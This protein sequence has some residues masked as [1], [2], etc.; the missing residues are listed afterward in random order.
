MAQAF[1]RLSAPFFTSSDANNMR[2]LFRSLGAILLISTCTTAEWERGQ[3][4]VSGDKFSVVRTSDEFQQG[5]YPYLV[6]GDKKTSL[7]QCEKLCLANPLCEYGTFVTA[8]AA[9]HSVEHNYVQ[10]A[11]KGECWLASAT[12]RALHA[13]R[14]AFAPP[15]PISGLV[16]RA[17]GKGLAM[18]KPLRLPTFEK[19]VIF[20]GS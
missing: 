19:Y 16:Q 12:H 4:D 10:R 8:D 2:F 1:R 9:G 18:T 20:C 3:V 15:E 6:A 14:S 7:A 11:A 13:S 17:F 5:K